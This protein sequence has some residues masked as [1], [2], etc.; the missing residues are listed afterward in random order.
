MLAQIDAA[1]Y[2]VKLAQAEGQQQQNVAQL[3]NAQ[4]DLA[5]Y[6]KLKQQN[7]ISA[8][9]YNQQQ[10]LVNQLKGTLK[11]NQAQ[12]DAAKLELVLYPN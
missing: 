4:S 11:S 12:I 10:S 3:Q 2:Q 7:S 5:L 8:Q 6:E 1:P 9:Q